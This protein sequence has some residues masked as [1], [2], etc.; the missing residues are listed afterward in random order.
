MSC[1]IP[2]SPLSKLRSSARWLVAG[3]ALLVP[4]WTAPPPARAAGEPD[5]VSELRAEIAAL[6]SEYEA[7]IAALE[8]R[9]AALEARKAPPE[10]ELEQLRASAR[11]AAA[12]AAP[13]EPPETGPA[14]GHERNL[15]RLNPEISLT[16]IFLGQTSSDGREQFRAQEFELDLQSSLDP[17]SRTRWT[18]AF[19]DEGEIEVEEGWI[20]YSALPGGLQL[21]AGKF[22][23]RFG[24]LNR[25]HLHAL[26][27]VDYPLVFQRYFGEEGLAQTGLSFEWSLPRPWADAAEVVLE[28]TDGE[29]EAFGG[30]E[31]EDL[32]VLGRIKSF[33]DLSSAA[34]F[35]WG[36]SG[37]GGES[38]FGGTNR[39]FGTD[40]TYHWQ[41]PSR[42]KYRELTWRTEV[43]LSQRRDELGIR[44]DAW[45]GYSYLEALAARNLYLGLR[46][47]RVE[48]PLQPFR[49]VW[50]V[51]PYVT[52]WQSEYVRLR[53]EYHHF[54]G[55]RIDT[56]ENEFF[57]QLTWAAGP[58]KH[59]IY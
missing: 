8:E 38:P 32:S 25:Q 5:E 16:G 9:L 57:L 39:V 36:L 11:A 43:L 47:D 22:R 53:A 42:A 3:V 34:W 55:D 33:W 14:V 49:E 59:E 58:H 2:R 6:K 15:N 54:S 51:A 52:F 40:F 17:F 4:A 41:P 18:L 50:G 37:V 30:E 20:N 29:S 27:Q 48:D 56:P 24:P 13:E 44:R 46:V 26:P 28:V 12:A 19:S 45:G 31:F 7:R 1:R 35:E 23:Q 21:L 10:D